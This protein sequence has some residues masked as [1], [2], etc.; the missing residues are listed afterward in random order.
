MALRDNFQS[1]CKFLKS[2]KISFGGDVKE[3]AVSFIVNLNATVLKFICPDANMEEMTKLVI[4]NYFSK[5]AFVWYKSATV[6]ET[7][8]EVVVAF[9][10]KYCEGE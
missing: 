1:G 6:G 7:W 3:D 10:A 9:R 8:N 5:R 4:S 2:A